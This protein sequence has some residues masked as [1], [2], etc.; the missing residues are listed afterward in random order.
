MG[1]PGGIPA[2]QPWL[3]RA[4][5]ARSRILL[6]DE[7]VSGMSESGA[8]YAMAAA[9]KIAQDRGVTQLVVEHDM[10]VVMQLATRITVM[11]QGRT[12][13]G[14]A[15]VQGCRARSGSTIPTWG[16]HSR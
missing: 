4:L 15:T 8:D 14:L 11:H 6:L 13:C 16:Q 5:A 7:S 9:Q 3:A 10:R 2:A 12:I 1:H